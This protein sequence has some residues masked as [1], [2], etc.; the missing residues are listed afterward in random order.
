MSNLHDPH[1]LLDIINETNE[2]LYQATKKDAHTKGLLHKTVTALVI[3]SYGDHVLAKQSSD[4]QDAGRFVAPVGGHVGS[5]ES[6]E[7]AL[8]RETQEEIGLS[9][10]DYKLKGGKIFN[11][12]VIDR[13]EN[14]FLYLYEIISDEEFSLGDEAVGYE[15]FPIAKIKK[16][17]KE[18]SSIFGDSYHFVLR[19][20]YPELLS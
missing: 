10:F 14:H 12:Y 6:E 11:R 1:E 19:E 4:R 13:Q 9:D 16:L 5:G 2:V 3:N 7:N 20:F 15:V 17:L 8:K 18:K